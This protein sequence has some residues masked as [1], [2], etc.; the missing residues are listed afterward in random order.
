[1]STGS[2]F[3]GALVMSLFALGTTLGLLGI[4]G[5]ASIFQK[6]KARVFFMVV[7]LA[8]IFLGVYNIANGGRL[9]SFAK[10]PTAPVP[11][12][13]NFQVVKMTQG[14]YG[15]SPNIFTVKAGQPVRWIITSEN[16]YSCASSLVVPRYGI[17]RSLK[18]GENIIE[19]TPAQIGEIPFSC[20][21]G[22]YR[23]KFIVVTR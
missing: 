13:Q 19:F 8:V 4:G 21:M 22:M 16:P 12:S 5:L 20:S 9:I 15:Y 6:K 1:M 11:S 2:F 3:R 23:G 18:Q 17:S 10:T 7:G 14:S